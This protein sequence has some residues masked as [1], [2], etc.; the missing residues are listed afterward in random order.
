MSAFS[1]PKLYRI[2]RIEETKQK[3]KQIQEKKKL[4]QKST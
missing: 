2:E 1:L 4:N 3:T